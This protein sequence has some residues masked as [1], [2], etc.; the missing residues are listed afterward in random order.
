MVNSTLSAVGATPDLRDSTIRKLN[1]RIVLFCFI[2]FIVNYLDRVNIG[3]AALHM[4]N[5]IGL[6]PYM[7]GVG[8]GIFFI[9][10]MLFEV[11]SN[12]MLHKLGSRVWI[13]RIMVTWGL[14][15]CAMAFVQGPVS[16]YILRF[17]LGVAEAGFA[18]GVLL[19]LT[20]WFPAKERGRATAL[21]MTATVLSIVVGAP[22]SGWLMD[23]GEGLFGL[24]GWQA[25]FILEGIPAVLLGVVTFFYLVDSP[26]KDKRWLTADERAWLMAELAKENAGKQADTRHSLKEVF[27]DYRVWL[28]TLVYMFNGIAVYGVIMWL[29]QIVKSLGDY[30]AAQT[31]LISAIPFVFAAI[32]LV[33]ISRSSDRTGER[34]IHTAIAGL[35]GGIFLAASALAPSPILSLVLLSVCAFFLWSY[36]G[37]FW[38]L[39]TQFLSGA[40]AA[41]GLAAINGFAQLGGFTG[42][43]L[44]GWVKSTTDSFSLS[45]LALSVFPILG[46]FL[47][48]SLKAKRD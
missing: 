13:A 11:P 32:G 34:K 38:T 31:G 42:P 36:L 46:F 27:S 12:M 2:C 17:L 48:M 18:P 5:D 33:V 40:A 28:L 19:Y 15:S 23:A 35:F 30:T 41:G 10:Y 45:L 43:Y 47:C 4:N 26:E 9:G 1:L 21:F 14:V 37:V 6:T 8:A 20:Y 22:F 44:V 39:P 16:F 7:F 24:H 25:M 3:Y 29:P